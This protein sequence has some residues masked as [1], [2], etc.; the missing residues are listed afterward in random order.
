[1]KIKMYTVIMRVDVLQAE[2]GGTAQSIEDHARYQIGNDGRGHMDSWH[3]WEM[4]VP[5]EPAPA[6]EGNIVNMMRDGGLTLEALLDHV[7]SGKDLATILNGLSLLEV[8]FAQ[9]EMAED[10]PDTVYDGYWKWVSNPHKANKRDGVMWF[11]G[12]RGP[13]GDG[14]PASMVVRLDR[15]VLVF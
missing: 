12:S 8:G 9:P 7:G 1:M 4:E 3:E 5:D 6:R 2:A 14:G 15:L 10:D 13:G 11:C